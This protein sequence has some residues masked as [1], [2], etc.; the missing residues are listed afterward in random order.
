[1]SSPARAPVRCS[2]TL[3]FSKDSPDRR[4]ATAK[5]EIPYDAWL[6][7]F[8]SFSRRN[9]NFQAC[10]EVARPAGRLIVVEQRKFRRIELDCADGKQRAYIQL[11]DRPSQNVTHTLDGPT[12][13]RFTPS[14]TGPDEALEIESSDGATTIVRLRHVLPLETPTDLQL[15][16]RDRVLN[17]A[18]SE[19]RSNA[20]GG[21]MKVLFS[22]EEVEEMVEILTGDDRELILEIARTK[23]HAE[24]KHDLQHREDFLAKVEDKLMRKESDFSAEELDTLRDILEHHE[25]A[26]YGEISRAE[27]REFKHTLQEKLDRIILLR[28]KVTELCAAA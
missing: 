13:V 12:H 11:G 7:F 20:E 19:M 14:E 23:H 10:V 25:R 6:S 22:P 9:L 4:H 8:E 18:S 21:V 27:H 24:F 17:L 15:H 16:H 5:M 2:R 26:L 3:S 1:M 28:K